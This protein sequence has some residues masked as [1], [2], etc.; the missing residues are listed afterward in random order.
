MF[1]FQSDH[2]DDVLDSEYLLMTE[3]EVKFH[4]K[5]ALIESEKTSNEHENRRNNTTLARTKRKV[6]GVEVKDMNDLKKVCKKEENSNDISSSNNE[7]QD[8]HVTFQP[9]E[10]NEIENTSEPQF[11]KNE[12]N[13]QI[14]PVISSP[15]E[16]LKKK[17]HDHRLVKQNY[18]NSGNIKSDND[19]S[20]SDYIDVQENIV[21]SLN[22]T[23]T[24]VKEIKEVG[25][26]VQ[27]QCTLCLQNYSELSDA[28][29][30]IVDL[31][32]P[33][34]GPFYCVVCEMDCT[35]IKQLKTHVKSHKGPSPY[36]C[37]L[38]NKSYVMKRYL[39]RHMACHTDFPRHRCTKCGI[40]L[41]VKSE[42]EAHIISSHTEG[43]PFKCS[44]CPRV[45]N[46]KGN[47]KRHLIC[48]LDPQGLHLPKY[49]CSV[50]NRRFLN[51]RTL[52]THMRVHTGEKPYKCN[53]CNKSFSQQGNLFNHQ[54]IHNNPRSFTCEVCG[55]SFNQKATLKDHGLLHSGEKPHVCTVC[56]MA[57]TFSAALRRHMFSHSDGKPYECDVCNAKFVGRYDLKRHMKIHSGRPKLKRS[58][59]NEASKM[60]STEVPD[61]IISIVEDP[62][63]SNTIFVEQI[64]LCDDSI[65]IISQGDVEKENVDSLL[66]LIQYT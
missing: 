40:R 52:A 16:Q 60:D 65:Q 31:H 21:G 20:D 54:K 45:F 17:G 30:H 9:D 14:Q 10:F 33:I 1:V 53:V 3:S 62:S 6:T 46:H 11:I 55:K 4:E 22:D 18:S 58:K 47:F 42:L 34:S 25:K 13:R 32:V 50:C 43:A 35:S 36:I 56:G 15:K 7:V 41:K 44:Q 5:C 64:F 19:D 38:C 59:L 66:G 8:F 27:Y 48:H 26:A 57:F 28:L 37:F 51:N 29:S 63:H 12:N 23:V 61:E 24:K 49:P 2:A 39:K